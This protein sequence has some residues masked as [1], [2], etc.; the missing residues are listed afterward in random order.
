M[1]ILIAEEEV[2]TAYDYRMILEDR[3]H[4][5]LTTDNGERCLEI[6]NE[7]LQK[8]RLNHPLGDIQPF[9]VVILDHRMPKIKGVMSLGLRIMSNLVHKPLAALNSL[10]DKRKIDLN[11]LGSSSK[12]EP[13]AAL[14][15]K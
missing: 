5:V 13:T 10:N 14:E 9:D 11:P 2:N 4:G 3:G 1:E 8:V 6:Y 7:M 12:C 15:Q